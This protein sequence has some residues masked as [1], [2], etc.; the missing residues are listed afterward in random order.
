MHITRKIRNRID[1][2]QLSFSDFPASTQIRSY[3]SLQMFWCRIPFLPV[4]KIY[5]SWNSIRTIILTYVLFQLNENY[6][7]NLR[8]NTLIFFFALFHKLWSFLVWKIYRFF[9]IYDLLLMNI[10]LVWNTCYIFRYKI[11]TWE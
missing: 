8:N 5:H 1:H 2:F 10:L 6:T 3:L 9:C 7:N 4:R 11:A